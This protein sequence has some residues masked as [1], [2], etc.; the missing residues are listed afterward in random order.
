MID[1]IQQEFLVPV[2]YP[3]YFTSGVF[4][5]SNRLLRD[6]VTGGR[7]AGT[8]ATNDDDELPAKLVV[9][10]DR[11]VEQAHPALIDSITAYCRAHQDA[12]T[13]ATSVLVVPGGEQIK[14]DRR[15]TERI[16]DAINS[17]SLCRHSYVVA[18]GGGAMLD[19]AGFA[20]ATAHRGVRLI[21]LPTTVLSQDD[22]A[23]GVK[24]GIN[25]FGKKNYLGTFTAPFA[26]V[27][28]G[29][30]LSTLS[31]RNWRGGTTEAVK[32]ALIRDPQFFDFL[33]QHA[34]ALVDRD[35]QV[36]MKVIR[37]SAMLHLR[38][39]ATG[40]DPFEHGSSRPLD[41]GH[42][43]AHKLEQV[44]NHRLGHGEAVGI[45]IALDTTYS[46]LAGFLPQSSWQRIVQL[47]AGLGVPVYDAALEDRLDTPEHPDCILRGLDEFREHLGGRL[48]IMLLKDIGQ[49]FD[50][51]E[52]RTDVVRQ[53]IATIKL[54]EAERL[55]S[56][57]K[58]AS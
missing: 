10:L 7:K 38:H 41:F 25:A 50:V 37:Q 42:W 4:T 31:D 48:T 39:I 43:A 6:I 24:N 47:L 9:V 52:V 19:A 20:A 32:A 29:S 58:K 49:P 1:V 23:V 3:V 16:I 11:G 40:G 5:P 57:A 36:M 30:F 15:H 17:S 54:L 46:Y 18:I 28:D 55:R 35:L 2:R 45:G 33:E 8:P 27:N 56:A 21:R 34:S 53:S 26:V 14:D 44:T 22:S 13:L 12:L 51:H